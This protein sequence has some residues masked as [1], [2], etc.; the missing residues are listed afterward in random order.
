MAVTLNANTSTGFIATSDT[1][2]VLQL[3]TG[4][5]T[6]V[7]VDTSQNVGI[8]TSS[9]A[10]KLDVTGTGRVTGEMLFGNDVQLTVDAYVYTT[11][12]G[13]GVRAGWLLDGT[14]QAVRGYTAGTERMRIDSSGNLLVGGTS[15]AA[16]DGVFGAVI[17]GSSKS[18]GGVAYESSNTAFM[19][20]VDTTQALI[21]Y[22]ARL[23]LER[24]RIDS[25][26][27]LLVGTTSAA[28]SSSPGFK[29]N[30]TGVVGSVAATASGDAYNYYNTTAGAYR[31]YVSSGGTINATSTTITAIS[32]IRFKENIRDLD[33]GL[34]V[35]LALKP[36]KFDWKEGKGVDIKNARGFIA[37]EFEAVL[38]DM[39]E[40]WKDPAPEGEEPYKAINANL[41][42]TLV[43]AIQ[44]QQAII[45]TL[46]DRIT[47]L[48][49]A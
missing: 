27:N 14:N 46:T 30:T 35:V 33:D 18:S 17:G 38:P 21:F 9:P 43:K 40:T 44:E 13:S 49:Q 22:D 20:Y 11:S 4:G 48:E 31:F 3:Q 26:G 32:D 7:T 34:D 47:A 12:G 5:T 29:I 36:R 28:F 39:I 10:R 42:P 37:Q 2:G 1:S 25:S 24:A 8:G 16:L 23:N 19:T 45:Q 6:A 15:T 41:I